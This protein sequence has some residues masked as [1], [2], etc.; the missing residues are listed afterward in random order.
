MTSSCTSIYTNSFIAGAAQSLG[1]FLFRSVVNT[2]YS[3]TQ[4]AM[5]LA[6]AVNGNQDR[7][8][9]SLEKVI[10]EREKSVLV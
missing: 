2:A 6:S 9:N 7:L 1:S 4:S 10:E 5:C 8:A 3:G